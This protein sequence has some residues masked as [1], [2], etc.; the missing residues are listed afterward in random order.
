[1][2]CVHRT[3]TFIPLFLIIIFF[4]YTWCY[5]CF[6]KERSVACVFLSKESDAYK[7]T[8]GTNKKSQAAH[9]TRRGG[10][11]SLKKIERKKEKTALYITDGKL[12]FS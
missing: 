11:R 3:K 12:H 6:L 5:L 7:G 2:A 8:Q 1:M 4:F 10:I 9:H